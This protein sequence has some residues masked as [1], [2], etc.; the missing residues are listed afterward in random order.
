[1]FYRNV[2]IFDRGNRVKYAELTPEYVYDTLKNGELPIGIV[3]ENQLIGLVS[4]VTKVDNYRIYGTIYLD[5]PSKFAL[6]QD[7]FINSYVKTEYRGYETFDIII[8]RGEKTLVQKIKDYVARLF[9]R[10]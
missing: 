4:E 1:M 2:K 6:N 7:W 5:P 3:A 9:L 8:E 10:P